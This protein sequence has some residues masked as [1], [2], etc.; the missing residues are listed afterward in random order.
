MS[1]PQESTGLVIRIKGSNYF[2]YDSGI[3]IRGSVRGRFRVGRDD[4]EVLPVVGDMVK[5]RRDD[6]IDSHGPA[7]LITSVLPR[8]SVF[9]RAETGRKSGHRILGANLDTVFLIH[10]VDRPKLKPRLI[11]RMLVAAEC[12][13]IEPVICVNKIDLAHDEGELDRILAVYSSIGYRTVR[14]SAVDGR[15]IESLRDL[16]RGKKTMMAGPSGSGK[17][18]ILSSIETGLDARIG[19]VS[20]KTGKG[21]HTTTHFELH[22]LSFGGWLGDTPG[23]REFGVWGLSETTLAECYREFGPYLGHCR[24]SGCTHSH[25]PGCT[26][27]EAVEEGAVDGRRYE[28]YLRIL[29]DIE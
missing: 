8:S 4:S 9:A 29:E 13:R 1:K 14:C 24:F 18:S 15:G 19:D 23:V 11:D 28:S 10:S 21:K 2:I 12:D 5:Y 22:K 3:E 6:D 7:G 25:E 17:T 26:L 20:S 16:M 27:K